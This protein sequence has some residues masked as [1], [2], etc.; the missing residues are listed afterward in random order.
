MAAYQVS[1]CF[2]MISDPLGTFT[3]IFRPWLPTPCFSKWYCTC[4]M[5]KLLTL[6]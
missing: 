3:M 2:K 6:G 4:F 1:K 5:Y